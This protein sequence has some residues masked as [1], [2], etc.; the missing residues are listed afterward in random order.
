MA[1][2]NAAAIN[3]TRAST[4]KKNKSITVE[5]PD[6][7][8]DPEQ[9]S[10]FDNPLA[11]PDSDTRQKDF[12]AAGGELAEYGEGYDEKFSSSQI[13]Q[14]LETEASVSLSPHPLPALH[15][16]PATPAKISPAAAATAAAAAIAAITVGPAAA[17]A[18]AAAAAADADGAD[19]RRCRCR[20][21]CAAAGAP[22][23]APQQHP[24]VAP[25]APPASALAVS[26]F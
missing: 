6:Q 10:E 23:T 14:K 26:A 22:A 4:K 1:A 3:T 18:A 8:W 25:Q 12:T 7:N 17:G 24:A 5:E 9:D 15:A 2:A 20:C 16:A 21:R 13:F 11:T 19:G